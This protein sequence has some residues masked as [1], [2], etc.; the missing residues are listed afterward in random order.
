MIHSATDDLIAFLNSVLERDRFALSEL[1]SVRVPCNDAIADHPTIQ[2]SR[3]RPDGRHA[4][5][6]PGQTRVGLLGLLNGFCGVLDAPE[7]LVGSGPISA[8]ME[9]GVLVAFE[10]TDRADVP[11]DAK[12]NVSTLL[13]PEADPSA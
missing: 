1:L 2:C 4:Y 13:G 9:N 7:H 10:R 5:I 12:R 6:P 8:R 3:G 11:V